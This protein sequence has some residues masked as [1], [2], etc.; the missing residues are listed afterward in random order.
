MAAKILFCNCSYAQVV[1]KET[2]TAVL[3]KLCASGVAFE[4]VADLCEMSARNDPA[5]E[6][7]SQGAP[8]KIAAC[9]PRAVKWLFS[10]AHAPLP[11]DGAEVC[12]MRVE[13]AEDVIKALFDPELRPNL[14]SG[15]SLAPAAEEA[16]A[17]MPQNNGA[18][19]IS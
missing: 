19:S 14:P 12:N 13:K 17:E 6:R 3:K 16:A 7:L 2:K 8:L 9:F 5:L 4:T 10:A 1:P 15:K 11:L 18:P